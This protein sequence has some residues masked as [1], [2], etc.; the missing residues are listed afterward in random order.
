MKLLMPS[1]EDA[2][3]LRR[4]EKTC[5]TFLTNAVS[6]LTESKDDLKDRIAMID[7]GPEMMERLVTDSLELLNQ[8][9]MTIP[10]RQRIN[11][12][13]TAKDYDIR[14]VPKLTP[15]SNNV[16]VQKEEFRKMIDAAQ[17]KCRDCVEDCDECR[18]C[19]L[20]QL[21]ITILPM[22]TYEGSMLCPYNLA[23]WEN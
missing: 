9:R 10:E 18:K 11:L 20:Y 22:D 17:V 8:V 14:L 16:I 21:L 5:L 15:G 7:G 23:E 2:R 4:Y 13:N 19:E 12:I 6:A 3:E 1:R